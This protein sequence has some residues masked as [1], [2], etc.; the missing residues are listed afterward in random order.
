M[1][2]DNKDK[3]V[4]DVARKRKIHRFI[5][6]EKAKELFDS[7][8]SEV[9]VHF[10][11]D[12]DGCVAGYLVC[13]FLRMKGKRFR[14]FI[15]DNREHGWGIPIRKLNCL[16]VIAVDFLI[17]KSTL[18]N[19]V[20][21]GSNVISIDHHVNSKNIIEY[22]S[23]NGKGGIV[24]NN[25]Y[26][27][28]EVDSRYLSGAGVVYELLCS[29][30]PEFESAENRALVGL[31][32]LS[33]VRDIENLYARDYLYELYN[34]KMKGY[35]GYLI[36]NTL[37]RDF[38]FGVPRLDRNY[39]D[40]K[41]SPA[42]NSALRFNRGTMVVEFFLGSGELDLD[43]RNAQKE[44]VRMICEKAHVV[45]FS[46]LRVCFFYE[47]DIVVYKD[48]L[49]SFVG[50]VASKHLD[51]VHS[52]ICYMIS[53]DNEGNPYVKRASFRGNINGLPYLR[54]LDGVL[55]G[56]GHESAFGIKSLVPSK[57]LFRECNKRVALVERKANY[58]KKII[59]LSSLSFFMN[60]VGRKIAVE[61][62]YCLVQNR[63]YIKYNGKN[64]KKKRGNSKYTEYMVDGYIV[65][66]FDN[67]IDFEN[68][69]ILPI[70]ERGMLSMYLE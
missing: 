62:M 10:D 45:D 68:G 53:T 33:D 7:L 50:L 41:F 42:I 64:I 48:V 26:D 31:T 20:D 9:V 25:Q 54:E 30:Y 47:K 44:L 5:G 27:S 69:L 63:Q 61:N 16:D 15:N 59:E 28:E 36:S 4:I 2:I 13:R 29:L 55:K 34:Y 24:I 49:S 67:S 65:M 18:R 22:S 19:I 23:R 8:G 1:L 56:V 6:A 12:V 58:S 21:S 32:L 60:D 17:N 51:G 14:W 40:Y 11:P 70:V 39:V 35:V 37:G 46:H 57:S 43:F 38:S 3:I 52:C 66:C